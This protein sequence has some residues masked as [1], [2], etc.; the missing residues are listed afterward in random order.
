MQSIEL[1]YARLCFYKSIGI[2]I[3]ENNYK[4]LFTN[5][6]LFVSRYEKTNNQLRELYKFE[7]FE[8]ENKR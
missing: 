2:Q 5:Q 3:D 1:S 8:K 4:L 6:T 7:D